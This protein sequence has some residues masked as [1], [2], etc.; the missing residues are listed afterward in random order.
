MKKDI[1]H[2]VRGRLR[3]LNAEEKASMSAEVCALVAAH[4]AVKK[5]RV[6]A[7]FASLDDEPDTHAL[8][9]TLSVGHTVVLPVVHGDTMQF[10][11]FVPNDMRVGAYGISEPA[12][13]CPVAP[14]QIEAV[15][16]PGV[17]FTL[18]GARLGRGKG[19]YDKYMSQKGFKASKIGV[20]FRCQLVDAIPCEEHDIMMD[21]VLYNN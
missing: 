15:V 14:S 11:P 9:E 16:V 6:V 10:Y 3:A 7:L 4:D 5:A 21:T 12:G 19:F 1:R 18:D 8:I 20:C 13:G 17:A 2:I